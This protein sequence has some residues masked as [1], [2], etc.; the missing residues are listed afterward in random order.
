MSKTN[1]EFPL[2]G[3]ITLG[4][5]TG[6]TPSVSILALGGAAPHFQGYASIHNSSRRE[7]MR[8][9]KL[10]AHVL[11]LFR[12]PPIPRLL[13][14]SCYLDKVPIMSINVILVVWLVVWNIFI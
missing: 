9:L 4:G 10:G 1:R 7:K 13:Q 2:P 11:D 12:I 5:P 14:Y 8:V 6:N 3:W